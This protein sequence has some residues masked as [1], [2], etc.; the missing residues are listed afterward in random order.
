MTNEPGDNILI[1]LLSDFFDEPMSCK[2]KKDR[3]RYQSY[4][5][6]FAPRTTSIGTKNVC[7]DEN[8]E[9][10]TRHKWAIIE[11][12]STIALHEEIVEVCG[13]NTEDESIFK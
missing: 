2:N 3:S 11:D 5:R 1:R 13:E 12:Y 7:S 8:I 4:W 9:D 10:D 6:S